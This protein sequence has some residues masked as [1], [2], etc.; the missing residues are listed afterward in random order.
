MSLIEEA[1]KRAKRDASIE[2][3]PVRPR[4]EIRPAAA[5]GRLAATLASRPIYD[6]NREAL[7]LGGL[8]PQGSAERRLTSEY[9]AIKRGLLATLARRT[10]ENAVRGNSIMV[11]SAMPGEGKT[12]TSVNLAISLAAERDWTVVLVDADGAKRHLTSAL[13]L[14]EERGL[15]DVL[16]DPSLSLVDVAF[17]TSIPGLCVI[18]AGRFSDS[19]T[20]LMSSA[21]MS[22]V[23]GD[24]LREDP[25]I[26]VVFDSSP[27]LL[28]TESR[29]L[30][31]AVNQVLLVV[32]ADHTPRA[33]VQEAIGA[34][35]EGHN[36]GLVLNEYQGTALQQSYYD[37][38]ESDRAR[39]AD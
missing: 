17:R 35:G 19:A 24:L 11:A 34:L 23:L 32:R 21:R 29:A 25:Q 16:G 4:V 14:R 36:I 7:R 28:T 22:Q 20:E 9:R 37:G 2:T 27:I 26:I 30:A 38:D 1:L 8:A 12:F 15:F 3:K 39:P 6:V 5:P 33:S 13:G 18:P 31:D 10:G